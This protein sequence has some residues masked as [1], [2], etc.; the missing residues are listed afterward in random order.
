MR[1]KW[2]GGENVLKSLNYTLKNKGINGL[3]SI[4]RIP[5]KK[6]LKRLGQLMGDGICHTSCDVAVNSSGFITDE[7]DTNISM[8]G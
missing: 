7:S 5:Q 2:N 3:F 1:G 6:L 4:E 8:K